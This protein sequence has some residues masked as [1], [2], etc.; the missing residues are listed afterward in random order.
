MF[1][2][3]GHTLSCAVAVAIWHGGNLTAAVLGDCTATLSLSD[4]HTLALVDPSVTSLDEAT[5]HEHGVSKQRLLLTNRLAMNSDAGYWIFSDEMSAA[6]HI[7]TVTVAEDTVTIV[8]LET[9]GHTATPPHSDDM[10]FLRAT[11][12]HDQ[13]PIP[14]VDNF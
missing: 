14:A 9:D 3:P 11:P 10:T 13:A 6:R 1:R 7:R 4:G 2:H 12:A 5:R 8:A